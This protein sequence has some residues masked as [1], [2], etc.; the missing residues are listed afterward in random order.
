MPSTPQEFLTDFM[1]AAEDIAQASSSID[2]SW[3]GVARATEQLKG[4]AEAGILAQLLKFGDKQGQVVGTLTRVRDAFFKPEWAAAQQGHIGKLGK[5]LTSK[6]GAAWML[7]G[8]LMKDGVK[9]ADNM[10]KSLLEGNMILGKRYALLTETAKVQARIGASSE[11]L[12]DS[13]KALLKYG[14]DLHDN[15]REMLKTVTKMKIGLNVSADTSAQ[16]AAT[17]RR[18]DASMSSVADGI[19]RVKADTAL[20]AESAAQFAQEIGNAMA[21]LGP[22]RGRDLGVIA[23]YVNRLEGAAQGLGIRAGSI[24]DLLVGLTKEQGF[25]GISTLGFDPAFLGDLDKTKKVTEGFVEYVER[26]L[27]GATGYQRVAILQVLAEQFNTTVDV[28]GNARSVM[29]EYNKTVRTG[30]TL[31]E[32]WNAATKTFS[33]TWNRFKNSMIGMMQ[34]GLLPIVKV[35]NSLF[36]VVADVAGALHKVTWLVQGLAIALGVLAVKTA[37]ATASTYGGMVSSFFGKALG[38]AA[39]ASPVL[40]YLKTALPRIGTFLSSLVSVGGRTTSLLAATRAGIAGIGTKIGSLAV[41]A[42]RFLGPIAAAAAAG[43][44]VGRMIGSMTGLDESVQKGFGKMFNAYKGEKEF[45]KEVR[46]NTLGGYT[47]QKFL[48][49]MTVAK[50]KGLSPEEIE[51]LAGAKMARINLV[52]YWSGNEKRQESV[53]KAI[54]ALIGDVQLRE[55]RRT[56]YAGVTAEEDRT[57]PLFKEQIAAIQEQTVSVKAI[58]Q[59][60]DRAAKYEKMIQEKIAMEKSD[61]VDSTILRGMAERNRTATQTEWGRWR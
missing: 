35:F 43:W 41:G 13:N 57:F 51:E 59:A 1:K 16:L 10:S 19:A 8:L 40:N 20:A 44:G 42:L 22:G 50:R 23:E 4:K 60:Q 21:L 55:E 47:V 48:E 58:L 18:L 46:M 38:P 9:W 39:A 36:S 37:L 54:H 25:I 15:Y 61:K 53:L 6:V 29:A 17:T 52:K 5:F 56:Q 31:N 7:I 2:K 11:D 28:V 33:G 49:D 45:A 12:T 14:F 34:I 30:T 26:Q 24:K 27:S 3:H 32:Q